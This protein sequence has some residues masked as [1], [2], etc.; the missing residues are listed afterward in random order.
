MS[1][2]EYVQYVQNVT[3]WALNQLN[4]ILI[5]YINLFSGWPVYTV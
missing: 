5:N 4:S 3:T 2:L 1:E